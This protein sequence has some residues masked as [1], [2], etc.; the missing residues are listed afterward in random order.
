[1]PEEKIWKVSEVNR[2][3]R[4]VIEGGFHPFWLEAEIGTLN[5]HRSGHVYLTLKDQK[6]QI[7]GVFF[8]GADQARQLNIAIGTKVECFGNLTVYEARGEYQFSIKAIRPT[9]VGDLQRRFEELK[10][11][12]N[13]EGLF[14]QDRK[15]PIPLLP[16]I[17]GVVTSP[18]GAAIRDFIQII[19]RR[20]P[21]IHIR[22]YPAAVQ[23]K[24]AEKEVAQGIDFFNKTESA[25]VIV[26]TRG[27][28]SLEDLWPFNEE[29]LARSIAASEIPV[30]SAVGH[31]IDFTICDFVSDMRVPTPSAAAELVVGKQEEFT[32]FIKSSKR[33]MGTS[34]ELTLERL[35][36][37]FEAASGST[38]FIEP[39]HI[40]RQHQQKLDEMTLR[41]EQQT[42]SALEKA[43]LNLKRFQTGLNAMNP[44]A[45]LKRGYSIIIDRDTGK[46]IVSP[47]I[48]ADTKLKG[49]LAEGE[50]HLKVD[51]PSKCD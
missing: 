28:G 31:E 29:V 18:G 21:N 11:R 33:R 14:D 10:N 13:T 5:I 9:G 47:D 37:R 20:F 24:G 39:K 36:R 25:D 6:N 22:I 43:N 4:D 42:E 26:V 16:R 27:G 50:V 51:Q 30:I 40:L 34:L 38:V 8:G 32:E 41:I 23:G 44:K 3:V 2:A 7:K 45:V 35:K 19:E 1:M 49:I 12:L 46:T 17:I 15:K 48:P